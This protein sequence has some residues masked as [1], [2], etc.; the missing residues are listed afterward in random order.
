MA[1]WFLFTSISVDGSTKTLCLLY[2]KN[3][4]DDTYFS[5]HT[6]VKKRHFGSTASL[7]KSPH[8][9]STFMEDVGVQFPHQVF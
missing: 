5:K 4:M 6:I 7:F 8:Q 3:F 2:K 1:L 9:F